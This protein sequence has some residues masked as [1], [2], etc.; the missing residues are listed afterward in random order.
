[1]A[2]KFHIVRLLIVFSFLFKSNLSFPQN[3]DYEVESI[4]IKD[5]L[6]NGC[7]RAIIQDS[8][9]FMWFAT[10]GGLNRY[11]GYNI[12]L[13]DC[14][15]SIITTIFEDPADSGKILWIGT[16]Q[17]GLFQFNKESERFIQYQH[18]ADDPH[19]ISNNDVNCIYK[20]RSGV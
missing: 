9:G 7:I 3:R 11:D 17:G 12:K 1:M 6:T 8:K 20:D 4:T 15:Q 14:K 16:K 10:E 18:N 5:G 13:Y 19:S 2:N